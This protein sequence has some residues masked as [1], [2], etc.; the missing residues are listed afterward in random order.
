LLELLR[1]D[2]VE[3]FISLEKLQELAVGVTATMVDGRRRAELL[4]RLMLSVADVEPKRRGRGPKGLLPP[5]LRHTAHD[6]ARFFAKHSV[7]ALSSPQIQN[8]VIK[9]FVRWYGITLSPEQVTEY[10]Y[11]PRPRS[12]RRG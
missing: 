6:L 3:G 11:R 2:Y 4:G 12:R 1:L 7:W 5:S 8:L 9:A 10:L